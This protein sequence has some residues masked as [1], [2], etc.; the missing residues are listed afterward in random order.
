MNK[1]VLHGPKTL[2]TEFSDFDDNTD[3]IITLMAALKGEY[4]SR[5][6]DDSVQNE[7]KFFLEIS[8]IKSIVDAKTNKRLH[9]RMRKISLSQDW[10]FRVENKLGHTEYE[11]FMKYLF[12]RF[13]E[14][15]DD[16]IDYTNKRYENPQS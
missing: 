11:P 2:Y 4:I 1:I 3:Y 9:F 16:Y 13:E 8:E 6:Y 5:T 10:R 7:R 12:S 15:T 14:L